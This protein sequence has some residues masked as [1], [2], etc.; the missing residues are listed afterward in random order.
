MKICTYCKVEKPLTAF[1]KDNQ[2]KDGLSRKCRECFSKDYYA[3]REGE[4]IRHKK[5]KENYRKTKAEK[6]RSLP[7]EVRKARQT[8]AARIKYNTITRPS[9]CDICKREC[10]PDA[11]H[12]DYSK[13][14]DIM[15]LCRSCHGQV[16]RFKRTYITG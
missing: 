1:R 3:N 16:H 14:L 2:V 6:F 15:W 11:H 13:P 12:E 7:P 4:A 5:Y 9:E 8:V 10:K